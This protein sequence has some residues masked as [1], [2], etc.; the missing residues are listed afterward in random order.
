MEADQADRVHRDRGRRRR[1]RQLRPH[2]PGDHHQAQADRPPIV[3]VN[4]GG[5]SG[6]E[7][8]S[9][10]RRPP[11]TRNSVVRHQQRVSAAADRQ[12]R[13]QGRRP[14]AG[15]GDGARRVPAV[16]QRQVAVQGREGLHRRGEGEARHIKM[17]GSQSKD[18]DQ[19]LTSLITKATGAKFIYVPFKSGGERPCSS[20]AA[21]ST[22]TPT[23]PARTSASGRR[24]G[25]PALR[26]RA[27]ARWPRGRR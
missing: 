10:A 2:R 18:T 21:I 5:G 27:E 26:V 3:V 1:H 24:A 7:G 9:T 25:E 15:R 20:P 23:I 19:T 8:S 12:A 14:H 13:L 22:R 16:G 17:G 4:K 11:A 6:A